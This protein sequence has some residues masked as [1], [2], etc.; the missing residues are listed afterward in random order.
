MEK[1]WDNLL[2]NA[3]KYTKE[4]SIAVTLEETEQFVVVTV[5]DTGIGI[6]EEHKERLF[7]RFYRAD[8]SRTPDVEG[9]GLGL[10]IV[11]QVVRLH[12][13]T[14]V[15]DSVVDRGTSIVVNLPKKM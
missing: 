3:L 13:G 2:S 12:G 10:A 11:D 15:V 1:V 6:E 9:T 8:E 5:S 7:E 4:G 14:V